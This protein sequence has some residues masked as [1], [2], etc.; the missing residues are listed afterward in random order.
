M[1]SANER[2][3]LSVILD[4]A[5]SSDLHEEDALDFLEDR[6][7]AYGS[8][9]RQYLITRAWQHGWRPA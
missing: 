3:L 9:S 5:I 7:I 4:D 8:H 2:Q 1:A 6:R